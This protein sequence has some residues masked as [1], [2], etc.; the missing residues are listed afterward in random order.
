MRNNLTKHGM[1][2]TT[3]ASAAVVLI[4][5]VHDVLFMN[6]KCKLKTDG[7][8]QSDAADETRAKVEKL[9]AQITAAVADENYELAA[10]LKR[11]K[12][13]ASVAV[14]AREA[15]SGKGAPS[16]RQ[17]PAK[18]AAAEEVYLLL[19][20]IAFSTMVAV[21]MRNLSI[22]AP[23]CAM[24]ASLMFS[25][26]YLG[27]L[28]PNALGSRVKSAVVFVL[29]VTYVGG[30]LKLTT[31]GDVFH[32]KLYGQELVNSPVLGTEYDK[33]DVAELIWWIKTHT[34]KNARFTGDMKTSSQIKLGSGRAV[35]CHPQYESKDVRYR[36]RLQAQ[37]FGR[38]TVDEM[39]E[40]M[41]ELKAE[42]MFV[43]MSSCWL[44]FG[45]GTSLAKMANDHIKIEEGEQKF[46]EVRGSMPD[47]CQTV[48]GFVDNKSPFFEMVYGSYRYTVLRV[49]P[50]DEASW[51]RVHYEEMAANDEHDPGAM[52]CD[53]AGWYANRVKMD[54]KNGMRI[55]KKAA[56]L[57][58]GRGIPPEC[59]CRYLELQ[60]A[61]PQ[62]YT[63]IDWARRANF[64]QL[65]CAS[66]GA[67]GA[68]E[69]KDQ[70]L[71]GKLYR[72]TTEVSPDDKQQWMNLY[73]YLS[74]MGKQKEAR[75][76]YQKSFS[77]KKGSKGV[78]A[79]VGCHYAQ[80]LYQKGKTEA[81]KA[82]IKKAMEL[83]NELD[84]KQKQDGQQCIPAYLKGGFNMPKDFHRT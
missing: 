52:L 50:K 66:E 6:G 36:D 71:A 37:M 83:Y 10:S 57:P 77:A 82:E 1:I 19:L 29:A 31:A 68:E 22:A 28:V 9:A 76:A 27:S 23:F 14:A 32:F 8:E 25:D 2:P 43:P 63:Q 53:L 33:V 3:L 84:S 42:Y 35:T 69:V 75:H 80:D 70:R 38:R 24:F 73:S 56:K 26:K 54:K 46:K 78:R 41:Q 74:D 48:K 12:A 81:A 64:N 16:G 44:K 47:F 13:A 39:W 20:C 51:K 15:P 72:L 65:G 49:V 45:D 59:G 62:A 55:W 30:F 21:M 67:F 5:L 40:I 18:W 79:N 7:G 4:A 60:N 34:P 58:K 61:P 11:Q 17:L